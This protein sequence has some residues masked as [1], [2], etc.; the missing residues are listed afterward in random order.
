MSVTGAEGANSALQDMSE[1]A[2]TISTSR[3]MSDDAIMLLSKVDISL[4]TIASLFAEEA[5]K[6]LTITEFKDLLHFLNNYISYDAQ[7]LHQL[8]VE[9]LNAFYIAEVQESSKP[10]NRLAAPSGPENANLGLIMH[11]QSKE[12]EIGPFW[13]MESLSIQSLAQKGLS[14]KFMYGFNWHWRAE[15]SARGR[16]G[17]STN[18]WTKALRNLH[19]TLSSDLLEILPLPLLIVARGCARMLY[20]KT[21]STRAQRVEIV[22][23]SNF[24]IEF[25]LDFTPSGLTCITTYIPHPS[26]S[27]FPV[28]KFK[29][30]SISIR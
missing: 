14:V 25:N 20:C 21:L 17:C 18:Y 26:A 10:R 3:D 11:C 24:T 2:D 7:Q 22:L 9:K 12:G 13:D 1:A 30:F 15:T 8:V 29:Q 28:E 16:G 19:D 5:E 6:S 27:F 23:A 4:T